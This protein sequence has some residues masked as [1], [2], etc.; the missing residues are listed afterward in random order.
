MSYEEHRSRLIGKGKG[1]LFKNAVQKADE[2]SRDPIVNIYTKL[3]NSK[4]RSQTY[5]LKT[6][7]GFSTEWKC[8]TSEKPDHR[9]ER[10][11][12]QCQAGVR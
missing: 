5:D 3:K 9:E 1:H 10:M 7:L 12:I 11:W 8:Q 6:I 2:F 4:R